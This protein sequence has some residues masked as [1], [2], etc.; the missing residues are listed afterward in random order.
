MKLFGTV[1]LA[2]LLAPMAPPVAA[3]PADGS[4]ADLDAA[5]ADP[6]A[7]I[8]TPVIRTRPVP[9][10]GGVPDAR[11]PAG[12]EA[13]CW[14]TADLNPLFDVGGAQFLLDVRSVTRFAGRRRRRPSPASCAASA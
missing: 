12:L 4:D 5:L 7:L 9:G 8:R 3:G 10:P 11:H 6:T 13:G 2:D 14:R 1:E